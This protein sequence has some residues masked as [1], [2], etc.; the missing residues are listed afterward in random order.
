MRGYLP[1]MVEYWEDM[2]ELGV[3]PDLRIWNLMLQGCVRGEEARLGLWVSVSRVE[4][5]ESA[6]T[7]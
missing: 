2:R 1:E 7:F 5:E 4:E 3:T 6:L